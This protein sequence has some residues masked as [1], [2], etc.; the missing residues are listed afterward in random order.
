MVFEGGTDENEKNEEDFFEL[1]ISRMF[2][3]SRVVLTSQVEI[4]VTI[5]LS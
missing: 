2:D 5:P 4:Q 1:F 3:V